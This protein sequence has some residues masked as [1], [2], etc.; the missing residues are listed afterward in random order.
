MEWKKT[1]EYELEMRPEIEEGTDEYVPD[2]GLLTSV[3]SNA[4]VYEAS[5]TGDQIK[6]IWGTVTEKLLCEWAKNNRWEIVK[7]FVEDR[8]KYK[9]EP[10]HLK[11]CDLSFLLHQ[12]KGKGLIV[13]EAKYGQS[14]IDHSQAQFF[15]EVY[16]R[17]SN[18]VDGVKEGH[19]MLA[20]CF[21]LDLEEGRMVFYMGELQVPDE[22]P[23][24][25]EN[26]PQV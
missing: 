5:L 14:G 20:K 25:G 15:R 22:D 19:V 11:R 24:E 23:W 10:S 4:N 7:R 8:D 26:K 6:R 2:Y 3:K 21:D 17:P 9:A 13:F 18:V 12:P 16:H 1:G